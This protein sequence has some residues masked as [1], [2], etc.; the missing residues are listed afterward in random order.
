MTRRMP[1]LLTTSREVGGHT[2][3]RQR[4]VTAGRAVVQVALHPDP[5]FRVRAHQLADVRAERP[6]A[7]HDRRLT[8][9]AAAARGAQHRAHRDPESDHQAGRP[10]RQL[11]RDARRDPQQQDQ[12]R[13]RRGGDDA[14][15][16]VG[17]AQADP[18]PVQAH[19]REDAQDGERVEDLW[20]GHPSDHADSGGQRENIGKR[21]HHDR[22]DPAGRAIP[23]RR[24]RRLA[25][26]LPLAPRP[27][28]PVT[29]PRSRDTPERVRVRA[30]LPVISRHY[31]PAA[32]A[33]RE[34]LAELPA[35]SCRAT[36]VAACSEP[37]TKRMTGPMVGATAGPIMYRPGMVVW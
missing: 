16:L 28:S 2:E 14:P 23:Q 13:Q 18:E 19:G 26:P 35:M 33:A 4:E 1:S 27:G 17:D 20:R 34:R 37:K 8:E 12:Q 22:H 31:R 6:G 9:Q 11:G 5:K 21:Q 29:G 24:A 7:D 36:V 30:A 15:G 32:T 10:Q 25:R 3:R